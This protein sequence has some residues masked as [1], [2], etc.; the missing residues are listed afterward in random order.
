MFNVVCNHASYFHYPL[1]LD[2]ILL[3]VATYPKP[4]CLIE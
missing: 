3:N 4:P 2:K 1:S